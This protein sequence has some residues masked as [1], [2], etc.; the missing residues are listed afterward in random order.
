MS[1]RVKAG[2]NA[3]QLRISIYPQR[4]AV[5]AFRGIPQEYSCPK[6]AVSR[7]AINTAAHTRAVAATTLTPHEETFPDAF[8]SAASALRVLSK[9]TVTTTPRTTSE[10]FHKNMPSERYFA[11]LDDHSVK[12]LKTWSTT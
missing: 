5:R 2:T 7:P 6:Y 10:N 1:R 9:Y 4:S 12:P 11:G 8:Q 3:A